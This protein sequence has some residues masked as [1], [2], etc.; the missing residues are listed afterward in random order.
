M[1]SNVCILFIVKAHETK[2][3]KYALHTTACY[4]MSCINKNHTL[5]DLATSSGSPVRSISLTR[6]S[7]ALMQRTSAGTT[8]P[9]PSFTTL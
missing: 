9:V 5:V 1:C 2:F 8:S 6:K 3:G 4:K 7:S